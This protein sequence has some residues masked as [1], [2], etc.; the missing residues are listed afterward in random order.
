M[1]V[2]KVPD[3]GKDYSALKDAFDLESLKPL[4]VIITC[5]G[6]IIPRR[7]TRNCVEAGRATGLMPPL[8]CV[9]K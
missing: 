4:D 3:M 2:A 7:L 9:W 5:K 6:A 8:L 1:W